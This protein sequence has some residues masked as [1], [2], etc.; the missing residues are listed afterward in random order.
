MASL[1]LSFDEAPSAA[2]RAAA[3][4]AKIPD[5]APLPP[6]VKRK[7]V[8]WQ[9]DASLVLVR[10]FLQVRNVSQSS[11]HSLPKSDTNCKN[12]LDSLLRLLH[13]PNYLHAPSPMR[14]KDAHD[15]HGA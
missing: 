8:S 3:A 15:T 5:P 1:S 4:A 6:R 13:G 7:K 12:L 11:C 10:F 2:S 9:E 14:N